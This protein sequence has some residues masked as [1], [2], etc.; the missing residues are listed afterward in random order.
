MTIQC[1][2]CKRVK[3][4]NARSSNR[5]RGIVSHHICPSCVSRVR[6]DMERLLGPKA[7]FAA[8]EN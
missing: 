5:V 7:A 2:W 8:S 1:A 3:I 4:R 6:L